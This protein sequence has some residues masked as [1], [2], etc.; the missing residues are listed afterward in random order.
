MCVYD[1]EYLISSNNLDAILHIFILVRFVHF[2]RIYMWKKNN[3]S[4]IHVQEVLLF[5]I[6][7]TLCYELHAQTDTI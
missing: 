1:S 7:R 2:I 5:S 4:T 3:R 6:Q